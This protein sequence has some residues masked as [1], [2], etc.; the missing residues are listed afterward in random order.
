MSFLAEGLPVWNQEAT[1]DDE[2]LS[3]AKKSHKTWIKVKLPSIPIE[4]PE[5]VAEVCSSRPRSRSVSRATGRAADNCLFCGDRTCKALHQAKDASR[6]R[7]RSSTNSCQSRLPRRP[8]KCETAKNALK[9]VNLD[10]QPITTPRRTLVEPSQSAHLK[11]NSSNQG[12]HDMVDK[13]GWEPFTCACHFC[14]EKFGKHSI[15]IHEKRCPQR[16]KSSSVQ[17]IEK[18]PISMGRSTASKDDQLNFD[19]QNMQKVATIITMGLASG[20]EKITVYSAPPPRP[21]TRTLRH[22][23]LRSSGI[24]M[25]SVSTK[26][27][28][29]TESSVQCDQC[30]QIVATDR[31]IMHKQM[32]SPSTARVSACDVRFPSTCNLLRVNEAK[33]DN[34]PPRRQ[35]K[36]PTQVCYVCGREFGSMSIAIH[37]PQCLKKWHTENRI[38]PFSQRKPVPKKK[39]HKPAIAR[40]LSRDNPE[41]LLSSLPDN[42]YKDE[43]LTEK[44]VQRYYQNSYTQ[45][46]RE[47][48]PCKKCGRTF[49]LDR[50]RLHEPK[51]NAKPLAKKK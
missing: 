32:C 1:V 46:E 38:L 30:Q 31:L 41:Q 8:A 26:K 18:H 29:E 3:A 25:P 21:H 9:G 37:E 16:Q 44:L 48:I 20:M 11:A 14:G 50:H 35:G 5:P 49:A 22:S 45:F 13:N 43:G 7:G 2:E 6:A 39:E 4:L 12:T 17:Q 33:Q 19:G 10:I 42:V 28:R 24:G 23:S 51:C 40:A 15:L 34:A 27:F 36:P 47:L